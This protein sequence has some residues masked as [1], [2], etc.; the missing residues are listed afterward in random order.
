MTVVTDSAIEVTVTMRS[1]LSD[2]HSEYIRRMGSLGYH[3]VAVGEEHG[4]TY[5]WS[6]LDNIGAPGFELLKDQAAILCPFQ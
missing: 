5:Y 6:R 4:T 3:R 1:A 2:L